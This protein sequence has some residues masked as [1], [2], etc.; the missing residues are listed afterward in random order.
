MTVSGFE[1]VNG[2]PIAVPNDLT[3]DA[4]DITASTGKFFLRSVIAVKTQEGV[5]GAGVEN[6]M[7][8]GTRAFVRAYTENNTG[9]WYHYDPHNVIENTDN[10]GLNTNVVDTAAL[11]DYR[12]AGGAGADDKTGTI[13]LYAK[14]SS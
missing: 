4:A 7:I 12:G 5:T 8:L 10:Q 6:P 11:P 13:W 9:Q 1:K 2:H 14:R 3:L